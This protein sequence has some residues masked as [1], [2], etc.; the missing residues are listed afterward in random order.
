M[1]SASHICLRCGKIDHWSSSCGDFKTDLDPQH[2]YF[3][4]QTVEFKNN[5]SA[6]TALRLCP[7]GNSRVTVS[8]GR[9][10]RVCHGNLKVIDPLSAS[11]QRC[12]KKNRL[13]L[14]LRYVNQPILKQKVKFKDW[15][16]ELDYFAEKGT[17]CTKFDIKSWYHHLD[18]FPDHQ[19]FH[20]FNWAMTE[21]NLVSFCLLYYR[22]VYPQHLTSSPSYSD[23]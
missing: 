9:I 14:D 19:R 8:S 12:R 17:H 10:C 22:S 18:I 3:T 23:L 16:V 15:K 2:F 21:E 6:L 7:I 11:V 20:G 5:S 1:P 4:P 13:I